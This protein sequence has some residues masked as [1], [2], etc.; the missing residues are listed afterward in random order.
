M[1]YLL[2][3]CTISD[4]FKKIPSVIQ[5]FERLS[6]WQIFVSTISIMEIEYGLELAPERALKIR[7]VWDN[8]LK[9]VQIVPYTAKCANQCASMRAN[10]RAQGLPV[11]PYD[12]LIAGSAAAHDLIVVTSNLKEFRRI[13][14][15][16]IE[17][18]RDV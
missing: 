9:Y 1:N 4:F 3:T 15:I 16:K 17:N 12:L 6:P 13:F 11:G 14:N 7:P 2:D 8:L 5:H 18:W 10:L